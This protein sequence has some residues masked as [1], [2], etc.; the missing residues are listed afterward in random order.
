MTRTILLGVCATLLMLTA[1]P[2]ARAQTAEGPASG[3]F[4]DAAGSVGGLG[5]V[6][7]PV[8]QSGMSIRDAWR[9]GGWIMWVLAGGSV[10]GLAL[11]LYLFGTLRTSQMAPP[12]LLSELLM[13]VKSGDLATARRACEVRSSPLARIALAA[14]DHLRNTT[15]SEPALLRADV[16]AEGVRQAEAIQGE[17][18]LL[19]DL[20]VIAPM[21]GLLGTVMGMLKAFGSV[22]TDVASAKPVV[23]AA[24]IS[25][26]IV[27]TIF[28]L[29]VAIPAMVAYAY[30]RRR[31]S[32]QIAALEAAS[33]AL[34]TAVASR[35]ER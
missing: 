13:H 12:S 3:A 10:I 30:F 21:L 18:Q 1:R 7:M 20:S 24:G 15:A 29:L 4:A 32:R 28:G 23:L 31:A 33:T 34:V 16:E 5:P 2:C 6:L 25:Q 19:L 35:F 11:I 27:T 9:C 26:A 14:F 22:A 17:T 8:P